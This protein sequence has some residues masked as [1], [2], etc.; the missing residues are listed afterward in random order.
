MLVPYLRHTRPIEYRSGIS[1]RVRY[2][3]TTFVDIIL[4]DNIARSANNEC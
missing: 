1:L 2:A 3:C 4:I